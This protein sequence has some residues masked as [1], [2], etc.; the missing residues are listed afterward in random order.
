MPAPP[1]NLTRT[2]KNNDRDHVGLANGTA[3]ADQHLPRYFGKSGHS[4]ADPKGVKK[5]GGGKGN[6]G[7]PG[8]EVRDQGFNLHRSRRRSNSFHS[9]TMDI[10]TKFETIEPEP[11]LEDDMLEDEEMEAAS[12]ADS[13]DGDGVSLNQVDSVAS[14]DSAESVDSFEGESKKM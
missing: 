6:W 8:D 4:D 2:H 12:H 9:S 11:V 14:K 13:K 1:D 5:S 3:E 7:A 10:K